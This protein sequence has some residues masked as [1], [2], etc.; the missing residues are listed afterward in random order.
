MKSQPVERGDKTSGRKLQA[1]RGQGREAL[2][3]LRAGTAARAKAH[4]APVGLWRPRPG[5]RL[6]AGLPAGHPEAGILNRGRGEGKGVRGGG[7]AAG[8]PPLTPHGSLAARGGRQELEPP[9]TPKGTVK[10][11][12][13]APRQGAESSKG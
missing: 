5:A 6:C 1:G 13:D 7:Q 11:R 2:L 12:L 4:G 8:R 9:D 3:P 10:A